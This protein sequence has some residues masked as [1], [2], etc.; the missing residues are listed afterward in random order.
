MMHTHMFST[1]PWPGTG[2]NRRLRPFGGPR[3]IPLG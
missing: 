3:A 2:L 1:E